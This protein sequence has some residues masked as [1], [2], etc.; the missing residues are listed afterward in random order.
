[1]SKFKLRAPG[2]VEAVQ[3]RWDNWSEMCEFVNVGYACDGA[4]HGVARGDGKIQMNLPSPKIGGGWVPVFEGD[5]VIAVDGQ[6]VKLRCEK[7]FALFEAT[8]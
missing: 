4:A 6:K 3:L 7:F 2:V 1:M 5:W 8:T